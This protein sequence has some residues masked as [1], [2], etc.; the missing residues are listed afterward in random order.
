MDQPV[1][2]HSESF[3]GLKATFQTHLASSLSCAGKAGFQLNIATS[4]FTCG[5][6]VA[7]P[8]TVLSIDLYSLR[9]VAY[10]DLG[11]VNPEIDFKILFA[12]TIGGQ[13]H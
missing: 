5:T 3:S 9:R 8:R 7:T 10:H 2:C 11:L 13:Q 12:T 6:E 4:A 1:V